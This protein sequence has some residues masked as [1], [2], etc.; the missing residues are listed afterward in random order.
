MKFI[1]ETKI[2]VF[3]GDGGNGCVSFRREKFVPKGGPDGG[4]GGRG[5]NVV[6][7]AD[8]G[9][10]TLFDARLK[11]H[12]RAERGDHGMGSQM[13]GRA[14]QGVILKVPVG[15]IVR[16][17]ETKEI[18]ADLTKDGEVVIV[19]SGGKGGRGNMNFATST[20]QAPRRA[21]KGSKGENY[22]LHLEL[23]LLADIGLIG[24]PNAGK[25]TLI[26]AI[27]NA[28][29]KIADYP[30]TTK[31]PHLGVVVHKGKSFTVADIPGLIKGAHKGMGLGVQF[32]RH[33][34]RTKMVAHLIDT[35]EYNNPMDAYS[36]IRNELKNYSEKLACLP[37]IIVLT[38]VDIPKAKEMGMKFQKD[39]AKKGKR[40]ILIS[41][42]SR[43][44]LTELLDKLMEGFSTP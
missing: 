27:S 18:I 26:S 10:T 25:S 24:L 1:D 32:L 6:F 7:M 11:R 35:S 30:F 33:I 31:V 15:T 9:L 14:G 22:L 41:A 36:I 17:D 42:V 2:E 29:P 44:G 13:S 43:M 20:N 4:D 12:I 16:N 8:G 40:A 34:E 23:K 19:A 38:K 21:E 3:A 39:L 28:R 5:G 37:E